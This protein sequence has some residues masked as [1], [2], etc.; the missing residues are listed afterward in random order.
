MTNFTSI[1]Q[2]QQCCLNLPSQINFCDMFDVGRLKMYECCVNKAW[3][4]KIEKYSHHMHVVWIQGHREMWS[5]NSR[6]WFDSMNIAG[7]VQLWLHSLYSKSD[8]RCKDTLN[9]GTRIADTQT[10]RS[11]LIKNPFLRCAHLI[12]F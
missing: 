9:R 12:Y 6:F 1:S 5:L 8:S 10:L 3:N 11:T 4:L 2:N 7:I